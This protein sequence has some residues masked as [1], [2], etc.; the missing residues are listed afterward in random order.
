VN[1]DLIFEEIFPHPIETVWRAL[2]DSAALAS[3]LMPNDFVPRIGHRFSLRSPAIPGWPG[4]AECEVLE[5]D[6]P[7]R[8]VWSWRS[9]DMRAP[10]TLTFELSAVPAGTRVTLRHAG[11][12]D[13]AMPDLICSRW[14]AKLRD[15]QG[16]LAAG[17]P[18]TCSS[19]D[20]Q[21]RGENADENASADGKLRGLTA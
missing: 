3:W 1:F 21:E 6:P 17:L 5:M 19:G 13:P 15:L 12:A 4:R 8:M 16:L 2:T 10:T 7:W 9:A 11:D 14:P 18:R 20:G